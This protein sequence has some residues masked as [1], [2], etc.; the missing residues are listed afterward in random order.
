[1]REIKFR[2]WDGERM[3]VPSMITA[4]GDINRPNGVGID[5]WVDAEL[6]QYIGLKTSKAPYV[7]IYEHDIVERF[8][9]DGLLEIVFEYGAFCFRDSEG[10]TFPLTG[11]DYVR[12]NHYENPEL[13]RADKGS[14]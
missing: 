4:Q 7:D 11:I 3:F 2:A 9:G 6:M 8:E 13:L 10:E 14:I 5:D 1:V 12:G